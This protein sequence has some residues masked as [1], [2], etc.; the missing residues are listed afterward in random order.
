M[1]SRLDLLLTDHQTEV[2]PPAGQVLDPGGG[3]RRQRP[4]R[5]WHS[6]YRVASE[7]LTGDPL[8]LA[9]PPHPGLGFQ[10]G[11]QGTSRLFSPSTADKGE[12]RACNPHVSRPDRRPTEDRGRL[13]VR[14]NQASNPLP[15]DFHE[16][17]LGRVG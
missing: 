6:T 12:G 9:A 15:D 13:W 1:S 4:V 2:P 7:E 14:R 3:P 17:E 16:R 5:A 10:A 8:R 11:V